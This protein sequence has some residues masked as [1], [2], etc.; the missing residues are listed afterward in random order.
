MSAPTINNYFYGTIGQHIDHVEHQ[1]LTI[2]KDGTIRI[3]QVENRESHTVPTPTENKAELPEFKYIH[4]IVTDPKK[5][6]E[7]S[8]SVSHIVRLP[9][10]AQV[11]AALKQ[12]MKEELVLSSI[13]QSAML[14]ELRR[15]GLP[16]G[17]TPG[18]SDQNFYSS[19]GK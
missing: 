10:M 11:C 7:V 6:S 2:D 5:S 9:K 14:A 3:E 16:D 19:Y 12:L 13:E 4:Y 18:F 17:A 15:L 1:V 8:I